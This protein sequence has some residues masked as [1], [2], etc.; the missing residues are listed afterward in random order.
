MLIAGSLQSG[1]PCAGAAG[2]RAVAVL[3]AAVARLVALGPFAPVRP[4]SA[5]VVDGVMRIVTPAVGAHAL[6]LTQIAR[7]ER[8]VSIPCGYALDPVPLLDARVP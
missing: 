8:I 1:G 4:S 2:A 6:L 5:A 7:A 3:T